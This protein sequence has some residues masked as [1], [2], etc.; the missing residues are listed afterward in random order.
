M[1]GQN[2]SFKLVLDGDNKGL[3]SAVK[4]SE[5]TVSSI[6]KTIKDEADKLKNTSEKTG[7][8]VGKIVPDDLK[9]KAESAKS[10]VSEV[11]KA[12]SDL[13]KQASETTTKV[14][15]LADELKQ[16][17][18]EASTTSKD[19]IEIVPKSTIEMAD[20]LTSNL[21]KATTTIKDAGSNAK[22]TADNFADFGKVSEKALGVLK[23]DLDQ[24]KQKLQTLSSTNATPQDILKA[25]SEVDK[26][27]NEVDQAEKAFIEF[28]EASGRANQELANTEVATD[29]AKIG[30][31][32]LK[33]AVGI[34]AGGLA[35]LGLG[36]TAK[37][38]IQTSDAT[39]QMAA[40]LK[41]AT[42]STEEYNL[43]Q[44]RLLEL[45][46]ATYRPL[47][48]AQEVYLATAGTM[49]SL[50]YNTEEILSATESLSLSFTHN[51][52]R[53]DQ[54]QSA[55]DAL[56]QSMAKGS[57]DADAW[58]SIITGADNVVS[59]MAKST[60]KSEAEI[61]KLGASGKA[62]L[63]DLVNALIQS[64]DH[65]LELANAMEN[66]TADAMQKVR[67]NLTAL[68]GS[69]NEQYNISSRLAEMIGNLGNNLDWIAVLFDDVMSAV[70]AVSAQFD[71]LDPSTINSFKDAI[72]SAYGAVKE[73]AQ[74]GMDLAKI[75][76][77]ILSTS[78]N[79]MLSVFSSF[80]G[81]VSEVGEQVSFLTR[82]SQ[83]LSITFGFLEDGI[84]T[85]RI[86]LNLLA[87]TFYT[88]AS[89]AN[90]V[91]A[92]ITWGDVSKQFSVNAD[93]MLK[94]SKEYYAQA[95][96]DA[97]DFESQGFKRLDDA[98]KTQ[99]QRDQDKVNSAKDSLDKISSLEKEA[100]T[101]S[102]LNAEQRTQL[103]S[104]LAKA[105]A[106]N[107]VNEIRR[108]TEELSKLDESDKAIA[109]NRVQ[110]DKERINS[111][112]IWAEG[113]IQANNGVLSE[114]IK[115][116]VAAKGFGIAM[117]ES[118]K[119]TVTALGDSRKAVEENVKATELAKER[120]KQAEKDYQDFVSQ[121][122]AK[123]IQLEQQIA[124]SKVNGDLTALK[125]SQDSLT[126]INAKEE[127]LNLERQRR[128]L[129]LKQ[130]LDE[131]SGVTK[132]A[133]TEASEVAK[134][135]GVDIDAVTGRISESFS[136]SGKDLDS[137]RGKL[138]EAGI[139][140]KQAGDVTYQ[141]WL[142]WLETAK[143]QEEIDAAKAKLKSFGDQGEISTFQVEQGLIAIKKQAL[144][145]PNDLDPVAKAFEQLGIKTKEQLKLSAQLALANFEL[146]RKSGQATQGDLQKAYEETIRLAYA[147]GDAQAIAT[148]N[149]KAA[150][151]GLSVQV[152]ETGKA[153]VQSFD[154]MNRAAD[155]HASRVSNGVTSAYRRMGEVAREEALSSSEA[156]AKAL[157]SQQGGMH[158]TTQGEKTRLAFNQSE[159]EAELKAMGYDDK[160]AAEIAKNIL[161][162]SKLG[163][164]YRNASTSWLAK[165]GLDVVGSFAGGGGG[166]SN[167][168]YVRE[169]LEKYTQYA[170]NTSST[171]GIGDS[172]KTVKYEISTGNNKATVY[173]APSTESNLNSILSELETI[174]K[175][176]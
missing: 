134:R 81:D 141:A 78:F 143:S 52:T 96:K 28:K 23:T 157:D 112:Q 12:T 13:D 108:I 116:E 173:G 140:G 107:E 1:A 60:G 76:W 119:I 95:D 3:V 88:V 111:A 148:A 50:G 105:R 109:V 62:S 32:N 54:A 15:D 133:Y 87:G 61:R 74:G 4:Q 120:A 164:G 144:Q 174:K 97:M 121:N 5:E 158:S 64:R 25:Q 47:S 57:V 128:S 31:S 147:S 104:D 159:V 49:K 59:D 170:G 71:E 20:A 8:E 30:F 101:Q 84:A 41:N 122:A 67:N 100:V 115:N 155:N 131:E 90:S 56:A 24:A 161:Q 34:L 51:A 171:M 75:V 37:E 82:V 19:M 58:M 118:G 68:I 43:V 154:E 151:L 142:K 65:N 85:I 106:N 44:A 166:T 132:R 153:T 139:T 99:A 16:T 89:A 117:D 55:Q 73:L 38:F 39:Q 130:N 26:L 69:M 145:L 79:N 124:Q 125:S 129:G 70:E 169:Q 150:S 135:F 7:E 63:S 126:Q 160:K 18:K 103:Q 42:A 66:S 11:T 80:T 48:E 168:N 17:G 46:N 14:S 45:A 10:A 149:S 98:A 167:A 22:S 152:D 6:F 92:A 21:N 36:L 136:S 27:E 156:W 176:T 9:P 137:F 91:L 83:G 146:V 102:R 110:Y 86:V 72:E 53:A 2:L 29:K 175:S 138:S 77:D 35:A 127:E 114:Q 113:L 172:S 94:K 123:K 40:R 93:A 33:S 165:N 162:G 163:D